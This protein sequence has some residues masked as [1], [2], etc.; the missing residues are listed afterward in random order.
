MEKAK[1]IFA[2][3]SRFY[4]AKLS[5]ALNPTRD[6][7]TDILIVSEGALNL[8]QSFGY[9]LAHS[10]RAVS[11][12]FDLLPRLVITEID[13]MTN[14]TLD[15]VPQTSDTPDLRRPQVHFSAPFRHH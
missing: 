8:A 14:A 4:S 13:L 11:E 6:A 15:K 3:A 9:R 1:N 10:V 2:H 7:L 12:F 5:S